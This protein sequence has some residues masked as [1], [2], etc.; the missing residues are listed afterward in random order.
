MAHLSRRS[1]GCAGVSAFT[2]QL[3]VVHGIHVPA[4]FVL[5]RCVPR[6]IGVALAAA[7]GLILEARIQMSSRAGG[8][9][10]IAIVVAGLARR[11]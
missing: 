8:V 11:R 4:G 6:S 1:A 10:A 2:R 9:A 3:Q 5:R 7:V